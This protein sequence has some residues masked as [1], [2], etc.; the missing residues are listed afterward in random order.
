M[1]MHKTFYIKLRDP[2]WNST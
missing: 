2:R 1:Q